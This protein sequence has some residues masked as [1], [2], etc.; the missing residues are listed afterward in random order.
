MVKDTSHA[1]PNL[2]EKTIEKDFDRIHGHRG[3][4]HSLGFSIT[5]IY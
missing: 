4:S 2:G 5:D 3:H 1:L